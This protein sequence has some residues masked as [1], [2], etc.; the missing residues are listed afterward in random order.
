MAASD[1]DQDTMATRKMVTEMT[2]MAMTILMMI[3]DGD[4]SVTTKATTK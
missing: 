1:N 2:A 4:G 3:D